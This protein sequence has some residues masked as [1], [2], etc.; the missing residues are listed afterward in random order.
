MS[1]S[2]ALLLELG[3]MLIALALLAAVARRVALSAIPLYLAVGL[4]V[5]EGGFVPIAAAGDFLDT[6]ATIGVVLLLL[7]L[8]LEFSL[9]EFGASLRRHMP[10][11]AVD[12]VLNVA[13]GAVAAVLLDLDAVGILALAGITWISS[14][15]V[16]SRLLSDLRRLGNKETPAVLS[17]LVLEDFA[18]AVFLPLLTVLAAGGTLVQ[19]LLGM[20]IAVGA[21]A[22]AF[23]ASYRWGHHVGRLV[24]HPDDE[25]VLLRILGFTLVIAAF[26]EFVHASAAVGAFL[27]GLTLTGETAQRA[28]AVLSPLRDLF[29]AVF[30]LAIGYSI[31]PAHLVP[32]LPAALALAAVT[33]VTKVLTGVFAARRDGVAAAGQIRAGT[34][35]IARGEF[36]LVIIGLVAASIP[37]ISAVATP[38]VLLLAIAGPVLT[39]FTGQ[40][41][42][43]S[44]RRGAAIRAGKV[45]RQGRPGSSP[46]RLS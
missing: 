6:G 2:A 24:N 23:V 19:A 26:A 20:G 4:T 27:V 36:S 33:A 37:S 10:S 8:G 31:D 1:I 30:F 21:L 3:I 18:M 40:R 5:G 44:R 39:R 38:Y 11:A 13:P 45:Y 41:G 14:S 16:V 43:R 12:V 15:G 28:R 22:I 25:Q 9:T 7:T 34:A 42:R 35:L 29:A 17:V 46:A 32:M